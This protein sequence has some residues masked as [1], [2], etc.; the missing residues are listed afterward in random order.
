MA[1]ELF[2][3]APAFGF[4]T[5]TPPA[6]GKIIEADSGTVEESTD[7]N[8][9]KQQSVPFIISMAPL[10]RLVLEDLD[11]RYNLLQDFAK[12]ENHE[13]LLQHLFWN[14][15]WTYTVSSYIINLF[16]N[17]VGWSGLQR[18]Q[19][20]QHAL[21]LAGSFQG[22]A[23]QEF[24]ARIVQ[25]D[26]EDFLE[27]IGK[28]PAS[29][30]E[31]L[32]SRNDYAHWDILSA[33]FLR[34][35][36]ELLFW[37]NAAARRRLCRR[38]NKSLEWFI[39]HFSIH[40][41]AHIFDLRCRRPS[42]V[43]QIHTV[44]SSSLYADDMLVSLRYFG[45]PGLELLR[46]QDPAPRAGRLRDV[47][48]NLSEDSGIVSVTNMPQQVAQEE[49]QQPTVISAPESSQP[50]VGRTDQDGEPVKSSEDEGDE[51]ESTVDVTEE[52]GAAESR[53]MTAI[54]VSN[55]LYLY[56]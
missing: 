37:F 17:P 47:G 44:F 4:K 23:I 16:T 11:K 12:P 9:G 41:V 22:H 27:Q 48:T 29:C 25:N 32:P 49:E 40:I 19:S 53:L 20:L 24:R 1:A 50:V 56:F 21:H 39:G 7:G 51:E 38:Q 2:G 3:L 46:Y 42:N 18:H 30:I 14:W 34:Y 6:F 54:A 55:M 5:I 36:T 31:F 35:P 28:K 26:N 8:D 45:A 15:D 33:M 10:D 13:A 52:Q 43:T